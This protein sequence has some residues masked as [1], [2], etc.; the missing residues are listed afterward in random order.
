M[1]FGGGGAYAP[2]FPNIEFANSV[3]ASFK[4]NSVPSDLSVAQLVAA[5]FRISTAGDSEE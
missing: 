4:A 2:S 5:S 1:L 3:M